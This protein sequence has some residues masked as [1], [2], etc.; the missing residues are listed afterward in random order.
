MR[1]FGTIIK[2]Q[3]KNLGLT[4]KQV[5]ASIGVSDAYICNLEKDK[6]VPPPYHTVVA[7]A[8]VL[9]IDSELLWKIAVKSREKN[10]IDKSHNKNLI[11]KKG[12]N[13]VESNDI[14]NDIPEVPDNEINAFFKLGEV[15]MTMFGLFRKQPDDMTMEEKRIVYNALTKTRKFLS[16]SKS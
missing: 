3:R 11:R 8:D 16:G 7:I 2:T 5:S 9:R 1:T 6:K 14:E 15:Q 4:L 10:A 12:H 13:K